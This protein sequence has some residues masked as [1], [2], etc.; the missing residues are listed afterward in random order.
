MAETRY[1]GESW[2]SGV[3][4]GGEQVDTPVGQACLHCDE[5]F[6]DGDRGWFF[7]DWF[8]PAVHRECGLRMVVGGIECLKREHAGTHRVGDH[9]PDPPHLTKREAAQAAWA[10]IQEHGQ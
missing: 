5:A 3:C 7:A 4:D 1:F 2:P 10:W 9:E 8:G 6:E